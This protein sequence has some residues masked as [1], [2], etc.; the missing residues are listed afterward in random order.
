MRDSGS[1]Y[2]S[3][4][5]TAKIYVSN[6]EDAPQVY[7]EYDN[8]EVFRGCDTKEVHLDRDNKEVAISHEKEITPSNVVSRNRP[9]WKKKRVMAV[10][11]VV[12]I[13]AIVGG[14]LGGVFGTKKSDPSSVSEPSEPTAMPLPSSSGDAGQASANPSSISTNP[15]STSKATSSVSRAFP[16]P[17]SIKRG[18]MFAATSFR[19]E[20]KEETNVFLVYQTPSNDFQLARYKSDKAKKGTWDH[21]ISFANNRTARDLS[22]LGISLVEGGGLAS[23][24]VRLLFSSLKRNVC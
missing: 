10:A 23:G 21:S 2:S 3:H 1:D 5:D 11:A 17:T 7:R 18:S 22:G 19:D 24:I 9:W 14:V 12:L 6:G 8:K 13:L 4:D 16:S 20:A 15:S